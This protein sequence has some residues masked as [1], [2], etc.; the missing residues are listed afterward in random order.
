MNHKGFI[1]DDLYRHMKKDQ[2]G[3]L[4]N[5]VKGILIGSAIIAGLVAFPH[6]TQVSAEGGIDLNIQD[7]QVSKDNNNWATSITN[8]P[9]K[10]RVYF[11]AF[12]E[13]K[14][15]TPAENLTIKVDLPD[16]I[17]N[18]KVSLE[19]SSDSP[20]NGETAQGNDSKEV[21]I[22]L[23]ND[24]LRVF[25]DSNTAVAKGDFNGD[26]TETEI[27]LGGDVLKGKNIGTVVSG[28][29]ISVLF[30]GYVV[31]EGDPDLAVSLKSDKTSAGDGNTVSYSLEI[32]NTVVG[33]EATG[34]KFKLAIPDAFAQSSTT[35]VTAVSDNAGDATDSATVS[36][37]KDHSKL[38][39]V[40]G[41]LKISWD[42]DGDGT[43]DYKESSL[44]DSNLLG[45]GVELPSNKILFGC[46]EYI[47]YIKF[48]AKVT[49]QDQGEAE[50]WIDKFLSDKNSEYKRD[51]SYKSF[52]AGNKIFIQIKFGNRGEADAEKIKVVD[53]LPDYLKFESG[54][55]DYDKDA[56]TVTYEV[57]NL[58]AGSED[59]FSF[60]A[61]VRDSFVDGCYTN[62]AELKQD[63]EQVGKDEVDFCLG[64]EVT[65]ELPETGANSRDGFLVSGLLFV[66]G[67]A[68]RL[69]A[70]T[71]A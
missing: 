70:K 60:V 31:A 22:A 38:V 29:T 30:E 71:R 53:E 46:Y 69:I 54:E 32:H 64:K 25:F 2:N 58:K 4:K 52:M 45:S 18:P 35:S 63:G 24:N 36:F 55:G 1:V 68:L 21:S 12:F 50:F 39:Y 67:F 44:N 40:P 65:K 6:K 8:V 9:F 14:G 56:N 33:T 10:N 61:K 15:S 51:L 47:A 11:Y 66:G 59:E 42:Q 62:K 37:D 26:G 5:F 48:D 3:V 27:N 57:K 41:S 43:Q 19:I 16:N 28:K 23:A 13:N 17:A 7:F 20:K 49:T 34:V